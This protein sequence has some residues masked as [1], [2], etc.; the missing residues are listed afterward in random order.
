MRTMPCNDCDGSGFIS[1]KHGRIVWN[2]VCRKC[3]GTGQ[4]QVY[5]RSLIE[6]LPEVLRKIEGTQHIMDNYAFKVTWG[7]FIDTLDMEDL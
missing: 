5:G 1:L 4:L 6:N 2:E 7:D 3:G